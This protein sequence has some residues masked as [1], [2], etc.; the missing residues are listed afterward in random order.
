MSEKRIIAEVVS[1]GDELMSGAIVDTNSAWLSR[2]LSD[3]GVR[4]LF[5]TTV[6]DDMSAMAGVIAAA[7]DR[8]DLV[9]ITGGLGPTEDDLTRQAVAQVAG[10]ELVE[11]AESRERIRRLFALRQRP[12]P[13]SNNLQAFFPAGSEIISNPN[14]TAPGFALTLLREANHT[15]TLMTFPGVPAE[16]KEM[17]NETGRALVEN[18]IV[19]R[20]GA[21]RHIQSRSIHCFGAGESDIESRLPHL[22]DRKHIPRVGITASAGVITLRVTAEGTDYT[23]CQRQLCETAEVIYAGVGEFIFGEG[24]QTLAS[25]AADRLLE[26]KQKLGV[27]EWG[28]GGLLS[29]K[30]DR[31]VFAGGMV[32][33][34]DRPVA[35][36]LGLAADAEPETILRAFAGKIG[37]DC[38]IAVGPY[39][40]AEDLEH[41]ETTSVFVCALCGERFETARFVYG[42][43]PSIIDNLFSDRALNLL[44]KML[45]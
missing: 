39:P 25:V 18:L 1:I 44:R 14:G 34:A 6:G 8:S 17:W 2:E 30:I 7:A 45:F 21:R 28:T 3:L 35:R 10:V 5:H 40:S 43:H 19:E 42:L 13:A 27:V 24:N 29:R 20:L 33:T 38:V 23:E 41:P 22:I 12:M 37:V 32:D 11:D 9:I 16:M 31:R 4:T 36:L 26:R 15:A